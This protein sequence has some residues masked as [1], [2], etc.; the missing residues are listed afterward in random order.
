MLGEPGIGKTFFA[1][2]FGRLWYPHFITLTHRSHVTGRFNSQLAGR[3][4]VLLDEGTFGGDKA[5]A[6]II[7]TRLTDDVILL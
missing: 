4:A 5:S 6:G 2:A 3:R 7:K 1:K